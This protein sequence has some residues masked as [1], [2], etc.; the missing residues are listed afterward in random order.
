MNMQVNK[1]INI[2]VQVQVQVEEVFKGGV[3]TGNTLIIS[4]CY[5]LSG[6]LGK[7]VRS[8]LPVSVSGTW[9]GSW[10]LNRSRTH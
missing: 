4:E 10:F 9:P 1:I 6:H 3:L 7:A 2:Q 5:C 8:R